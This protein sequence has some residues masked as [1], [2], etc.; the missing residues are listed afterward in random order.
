MPRLLPGAFAVGLMFATASGTA[1]AVDEPENIV[2]YRQ[3]TMQALGAHISML[4]AVAKNEVSFRDQ[5]FGHA[6][7]INQMSDYLAELFPEGTGQ[8]ETEEES[9]ALPA[10]WENPEEFQAAIESLQEES[11][12]MVQA[13]EGDDPTAFA[14]QLGALGKQ[15]CGNCHD[16]FRAEDD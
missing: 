1:L 16:D 9:D 12:K 3:A 11:E 10:I 8:G 5:A 13:A 6:H 2:K 4:A 14:Q 15:G 7:A